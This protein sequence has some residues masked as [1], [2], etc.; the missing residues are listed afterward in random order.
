MLENGRPRQAFF[1]AVAR[2]SG[3]GIEFQCGRQRR[4]QNEF[5]LWSG[6]AGGQDVLCWP[7]GK[8]GRAKREI[9]GLIFC[10]TKSYKAWSFSRLLWLF[11]VNSNA[12]AVTSGST[13]N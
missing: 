7:D 12:L 9:D 8:S 3:N 10:D 1:I 5:V 11:F 2:Q 6:V 4:K 13:R